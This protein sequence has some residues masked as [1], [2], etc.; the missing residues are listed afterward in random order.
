[1]LVLSNSL[2]GRLGYQLSYVLAKADGNV[3]NSVFGAW[4]NGTVW[5][6]PN[7]AIINADGELTNSRRHEI[8]GLRDLHGAASGSHARRDLQRPQWAPYTP[9]GQFST[10]QLN[11]P[12]LSRRQILPAPRG[13]ERNDYTNQIDIRA[14][15]A[16]T[17]ESHRFGIFADITNIFNS[18]GVITRQTR[19]PSTTISDS[20]VLYQA[21]TALLD[22]RQVSFGGRWGF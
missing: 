13:T 19:S 3:D 14:E 6:S 9:Y 10:S 11:L 17:I 2:R 1:M 12:G 22:A 16:F 7:T 21:P 15:K 5:D 8:Q 4:L 20:T 18:G